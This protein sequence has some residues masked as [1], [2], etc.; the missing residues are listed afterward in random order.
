MQIAPTRTPYYQRAQPWIALAVALVVIGIFFRQQLHN[1]FAHLS[2]D[3]YDGMIQVALLEHWY[4]VVTGWSHWNSPNYFYPYPKTLGY[5]EGQF[6]YGLI[7]SAFRLCSIDAFAANELVNM[8]IKAIGFFGFLAAARRMLKLPFAWALLGAAVFTL[9]N[10]SYL[11]LSHAQLLSVALAPAQALLIHEALQSLHASQGKRLFKFGSLAALL[12]AA[13][14]ITCLYT[15][16]FF[17]TFTVIVL[18]VQLVLMGWPGLKRLRAALVANKLPLLG[19]AV[20]A[21]IAV[22]PFASVYAAGGVARQ[23]PWSEIMYYIPTFFDSFNVGPG[24]LLFGGRIEA[25]HAGCQMCDLGIG[26]REAGLSPIL[27]VLAGMSILAIFKRELVVPAAIRTAL[28][29]IAAASLIL[30]VLAIRFDQDSGWLWIYNY[31]PG[32]GGLRVVARVF[33]FLALPATALAVWYLSRS[34]WPRLV[35]LALCALLLAEQIN[36]SPLTTLDRHQ[37]IERTSGMPTP[38]ATCQ[39]FFT[40]ES[41]DTVDGDPSFV[42][43]ALYPHNVDAMLIAEYAH[44]PTINGFASFNPADW[45]FGSP[46]S[47]DYRL[48]VQAYAAAHKLQGLCELDLINKRWITAPVYT[49]TK[50]R[51]AYWDLASKEIGGLSL[52][53]LGPAE[54]FGRWSVGRESHLRYTLPAHAG[55]AE[56]KLKIN[57]I[58][59]LVTDRHH[60]RMLVSINGGATQEFVF[61]TTGRANVEL[62]I[63]AK[64]GDRIDVLLRF[65]E[66]ISPRQLNINADE[67]LLAVGIKSIEIQ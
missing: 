44:L 22:L 37:L 2:G 45:N 51:L 23:R 10:N 5:N 42:V 54:S 60:Q 12:F 29:G 66:A 63:P 38:P 3:R 59:A 24:N 9:S 17:A 49:A 27:L 16:W 34:A 50:A 53:G 18:A 52:E 65:P 39:S 46:T 43:G 58:T 55:D 47:P 64:A 57:L 31:W 4:N 56:L 35:V 7:Y 15:A 41:P 36:L 20:V 21:L 19:I 25:L 40:A 26:E 30:F 14:M 6:L 1:H 32:G 48:R 8:T 67:R 33:L 11:Q 28:V 61:G 13:W 62:P